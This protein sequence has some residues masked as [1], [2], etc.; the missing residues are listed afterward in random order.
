MSLH[1]R[2]FLVFALFTSVLVGCGAKER[3]QVEFNISGVA[4]ISQAI[5]PY[6]VAEGTITN[7][8]RKEGS[9]MSH[10]RDLEIYDVTVHFNI[11]KEDGTVLKGNWKRVGPGE[12]RLDGKQTAQYEIVVDFHTDPPPLFFDYEYWSTYTHK[13]VT[14]VYDDDDYWND[15][16][17][18]EEWEGHTS[19]KQYGHHPPGDD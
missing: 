16:E 17:Y 11:L 7:L 2:I 6:V 1:I 14:E 3:Y 10:S 5:P 13:E 9:T 12:S 15:P 19:P 18:R 8:S 4:V